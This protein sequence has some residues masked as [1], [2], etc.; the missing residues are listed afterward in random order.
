[1][2]IYM[3][4]RT[5]KNIK[6]KRKIGG[7]NFL[8]NPIKES[9]DSFRHHLKSHVQPST[10]SR[11][12]PGKRNIPDIL[13][14]E[15]V[16]ASPAVTLPSYL[17][18]KERKDKRNRIIK[19]GGNTPSIKDSSYDIEN[20][21]HSSYDI[22]NQKHRPLKSKFFTRSPFSDSSSSSSS[23]SSSSLS[24]TE[25]FKDTPEVKSLIEKMSQGV[26]NILGIGNLNK[27]KK[28]ID[29]MTDQVAKLHKDLKDADIKEFEERKKAGLTF[30]GKRRKLR[31]R[32][33]T[34]KR[35]GDELYMSSGDIARRPVQQVASRRSPTPLEAS[36]AAYIA[37]NKI[38]G[39]VG[40]KKRT[41]G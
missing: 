4:Y 37:S 23:E 33:R 19:G 27:T 14:N 39:P 5:I 22:E 7:G 2:G 6:K 25:S 30:G 10:G 9:I 11:R 17:T 3:R 20:Q 12:S 32:R 24:S 16:T 21:K 40:K 38:T 13:M 15:V 31:K 1:M 18:R 8:S 36:K 28:S 26:H 35:G 41:M 29:N 34:R